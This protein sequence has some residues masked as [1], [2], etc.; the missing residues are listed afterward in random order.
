MRIQGSVFSAIASQFSSTSRMIEDL[1]DVLHLSRASIYKR[2]NGSISLNLSEFEFLLDHYC[3]DIRKIYQLEQ[4]CLR[5]DLPTFSQSKPD[6]FS[7]LQKLHTELKFVKSSDKGVIKFLSSDLPIFYWF[8]NERLA[9]FKLFVCEHI[10]WHPY[11]SIASNKKFHINTPTEQHYSKIYKEL[12]A[13]YGAINSEEIWTTRIFETYIKQLKYALESGYFAKPK[14]ALLL[15]DE[16]YE[17]A[18]TLETMVLAKSKYQLSSKVEGPGKLELRYYDLDRFTNTFLTI[19]PTS[20]AVFLSYDLPNF[21]KCKDVNF[22]EYANNW[23]ATIKENSYPLTDNARRRQHEYF[24]CIRGVL[25]KE[26]D[27][28]LQLF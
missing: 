28:I 4:R 26:K 10:L 5:F 11:E 3:I 21:L 8:C 24:D 7:Y 9:N 25:Q 18:N 22:I 12:A 27:H 13:L 2:V 19:S 20:S 23:I 17:L 1:S 14:E 16:L 6:Y 15:M